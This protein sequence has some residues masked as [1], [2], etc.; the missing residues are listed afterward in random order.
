MLVMD[1][2]DDFNEGTPRLVTDQGDTWFDFDC[3]FCT[4]VWDYPTQ[5]GLFHHTWAV[6]PAHPILVGVDERAPSTVSVSRVVPN[7]TL[8]A[9]RFEF[10]LVAES[11]VRVE[12]VDLAGRVV[13]TLESG[14]L[15]AGPHAMAWDG[16]TT[17]GARVPSGLYFYRITAGTQSAEGRI[18]VI[19]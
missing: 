1:C 17:T 5:R 6:P 11:N 19:R 9:T 8:G 4:G 15:A 7:P 14:R 13:R 16:R 10:A 12:V 18:A 2:V 3:D